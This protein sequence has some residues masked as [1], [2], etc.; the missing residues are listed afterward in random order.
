MFDEKTLTESQEAEARWRAAFDRLGERMESNGRPSET[1]SGL[2]IKNAYFPHDIEHL[3]FAQIGTSGSYPFTWR[4][5]AAS[6]EDLID[7]IRKNVGAPKEELT[8]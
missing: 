7:F 4:N 6:A 2:P 1:Q 3:E 5:L 8:P